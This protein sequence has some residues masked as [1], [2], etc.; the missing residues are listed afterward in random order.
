MMGK[1]LW[2]CVGEEESRKSYSKDESKAQL[3]EKREIKRFQTIT[4]STEV[5][6]NHWMNLDTTVYLSESCL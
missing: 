2:Q 3:R 5:S 1:M 4:I 6:P